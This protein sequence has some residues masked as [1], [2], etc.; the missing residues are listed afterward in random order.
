MGKEF[1]DFS[2]TIKAEDIKED[3]T[4]SGYGSLSDKNKDSYGDII[5]PGAFRE[6]LLKGGRNRTGI[7]M[8]WQHRSDKIPGVW[9]S[10][11]ED[12]IGLKVKGQLA[13]KTSLGNDTYEIMKLSAKLG[14]FQMGMSIGY[15]AKEVEYD[16]DN[17]IRTIKRLELWELSLV[18]FPAKIG[19]GVDTVKSIED[20][21]TIREI[22]DALRESGHTKS[23]S[24]HIVQ[25][26]KQS[27]RDSE[28]KQIEAKAKLKA[29]EEKEKEK[30]E[31]EEKEKESLRESEILKEVLETI[32]EVK[33]NNTP[34]K[35]MFSGILKN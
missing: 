4:F 21:N 33:K 13:L 32:K 11:E 26:I 8:L 19:A 23:E 28:T 22:E 29:K 3:G 27:L 7:P 10:L 30:E 18:T 1:K 20:A 25:A 16:K 24:Q 14:T 15:D 17:R 12:K 2:F 31:K 6:T 5:A 34:E 35:N 9:I